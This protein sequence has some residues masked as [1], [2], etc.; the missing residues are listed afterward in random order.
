MAGSSGIFS[1]QGLGGSRSWGAQGAGPSVMSMA[2]VAR[3]A[4]GGH[5]QDPWLGSWVR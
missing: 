1:Q 3:L 4:G 2:D 5:L